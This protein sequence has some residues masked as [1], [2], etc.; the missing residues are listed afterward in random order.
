MGTVYEAESLADGSRVA[1]KVISPCI[2][3]STEDLSRFTRE[4]SILRDLEHPHIVRFREFNQHAGALFI[5]MDY[6]QGSTVANLIATSTEFLP[7]SRAVGLTLQLLEALDFAHQRGYVHRDV[8]PANLLIDSRNG[9]DWLSLAD[10]GLARTYQ[11][12]KLSGLTVTGDVGGTTPFMPPEQITNYRS[13][14]AAADQYSTAATLYYLLT[15]KYVYDL[16]KDVAKQLLMILQE[17]PVKI[18]K[19]RSDLTPGLAKIIHRALS[20]DP[21][22]RFPDV[23]TFQ[24]ALRLECPGN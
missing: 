10:F 15:R 21:A 18:D 5:V 8:K 14:N 1:I 2:S 11:S 3:A 7:V 16:P 24:A 4:A 23:A 19:R 22:A 12:S 9:M 20:R 6:I 17:D 13:V